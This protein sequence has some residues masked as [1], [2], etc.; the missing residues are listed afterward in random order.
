MGNPWS[1]A[2]LPSMGY[3]CVVH[4]IAKR[5]PHD[6]ADEA[7]KLG[8]GVLKREH[9]LH[10]LTAKSNSKNKNVSA[11]LC[12]RVP[13]LRGFALLRKPRSKLKA[14]RNAREKRSRA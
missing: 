8:Y 13:R 3:P 10:V 14:A 2:F 1:A 11:T 6:P 4:P 9:V 12:V 5:S 7:K